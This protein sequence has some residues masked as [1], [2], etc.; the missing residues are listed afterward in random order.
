MK[1]TQ[2]PWLGIPLDFTPVGLEG[3]V[4]EVVCVQSQKRYIGR[5]YFMAK[6]SKKVKT[7]KGKLSKK[8][9]RCVK[10]SDW[11]VY[12]SSSDELKAEIARLG[13]DAFTFTILSLHRTRAETNYEEVRQQFLRDVLYSKLP[14]GEYEYFNYCIL[15]RYWRKPEGDLLSSP[16]RRK[17]LTLEDD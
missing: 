14:N 3:F 2:T 11:R 16:T 10:E 6:T 12:K 7:A 13:I 5:K 8:K 4:Y 9:K 1:K 15:N 17:V